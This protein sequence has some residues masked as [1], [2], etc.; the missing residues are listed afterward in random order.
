[1]W[2]NLVRFNV[3]PSTSPSSENVVFS[4][5]KIEEDETKRSQT[6]YI[7]MKVQSALI[8]RLEQ[9]WR[10]CSWLAID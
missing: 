3:E 8:L 6:H 1:M 4:Y 5:K 7:L 2:S 10:S 9:Y